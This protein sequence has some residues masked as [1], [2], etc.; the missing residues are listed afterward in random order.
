MGVKITKSGRTILTGKDYTEQK[1]VVWERQGR[2]CADCGRS[3][4]DPRY[5]HYHHAKGRSRGL[6]DDLDPANKLLCGII[7]HGQRHGQVKSL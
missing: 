7:C 2:K 1:R 4:P 5:A 3:I 6:R